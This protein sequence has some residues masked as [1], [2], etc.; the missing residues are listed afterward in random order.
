MTSKHLILATILSLFVLSSAFKTQMHSLHKSKLS[1]QASLVPSTETGDGQFNQT[2]SDISAVGNIQ[3]DNLTLTSFS[4]VNG[5]GW[6]SATVT[7]AGTNP[8]SQPFTVE[9]FT[10]QTTTPNINQTNITVAV[11]GLDDK[12][13]NPFDAYIT[14]AVSTNATGS[15]INAI[16]NVTGTYKGTPFET[17]YALVGGT[18]TNGNALSIQTLQVEGY[19]NGQPFILNVQETANGNAT[20]VYTSSVTYPPTLNIPPAT[21]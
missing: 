4:V 15:T 11:Q 5:S 19:V 21:Q 12:T 10:N 16:A 18:V 8:N 20:P 13:G 3:N 7:E 6:Q 1:P 17:S 14:L 9:L 2:L